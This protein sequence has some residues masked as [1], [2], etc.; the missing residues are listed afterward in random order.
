MDGSLE[1]A[2]NEGVRQGYAGGYL[3]KSVCDPLTR[4]NT[5]DNTP[6]IIHVTIIEG[7][8]V[9]IRFAP[10]GAGR[11]RTRLARKDKYLWH[12]AHGLGGRGDSPRRAY[13]DPPLPHSE[14]SGGD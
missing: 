10:K 11:N 4:K 3:R 9:R 14:P 5:N 6:A 7:D 13:K 8:K 12:G 1:D 2:I